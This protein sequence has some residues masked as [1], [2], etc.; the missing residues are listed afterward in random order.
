MMNTDLFSTAEKNVHSEARACQGLMAAV[1]TSAISD[2]CRPP[3]KEAVKVHGEKKKKGN[4][5]K[6]KPHTPTSHARTGMYFLFAEDGG[7]EYYSQWLD[8]APD[9]FRKALLAQ[10]YDEKQ[11]EAFNKRITPQQ[12]RNFRFNYQW[13]LRKHGDKDINE[14]MYLDDDED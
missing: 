8:I 4:N 9:T 11:W 5:E 7:L 10:M 6:Y 13:H 1:I 14:S 12:K 2:A 3:I